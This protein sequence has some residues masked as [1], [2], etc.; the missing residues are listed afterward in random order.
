MV[1]DFLSKSVRKEILE[2]ISPSD[3]EV[4]RQQ[5]IIQ[6]ISDKLESYAERV[7]IAYSFIQPQGS[8]GRKQTQLKGA[9]DIDL[10]VGLN[11]DDF[12]EILSLPRKQR[13]Q[14]LDS[15]FDEM[16]DNWFMPTLIEM[17]TTTVQKTYSQHPYLSAKFYPRKR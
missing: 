12:T 17:N 14:E 9:S 5:T 11:P 15:I 4:K 10:F 6:E 3:D 1:I 8:T 2:K 7:N 13:D 16:V